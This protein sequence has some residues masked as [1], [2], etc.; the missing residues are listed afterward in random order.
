MD[1]LPRLRRLLFLALAASVLDLAGE[2]AMAQKVP[3][4]GEKRVETAEL[5][6]GRRIAGR[7]V[8]ATAGSFRF[9]TDQGEAI[10]LDKIGEITVDGPGPEPSTGPP[11]FQIQLGSWSRLSGR[12]LSIDGSTIRVDPGSDHPPLQVDRHGVTSVIQRPGEVQSLKDGFETLD[13]NRWSPGGDADLVAIP[14]LVGDR[15]ARLPAGGSSL[16]MRLVEPLGSGRLELAYFDEGERVPGQRW[17]VDLTF[18]R[19][20]SESTTVRVVL[21]WAEETLAVETPGGPALNVQRLVRKPGWH[22]LAVKFEPERAALSV[23]GDELAHG[24]GFGGPLFEIRMATE[25]LGVVQPLKTLGAVVDDLSLVRFTQPTGRF[26]VE[27]AQDE[28]RLLSGDQ[29]FGRFLGADGDRLS[30]QLDGKTIRPSW[31]D[32]SGIHFRR[33]AASADPISGLWVRVE[34]RT[35]PGNDIRDLDRI[36]A[37]L[38]AIDEA[39]LTLDAPYV[40][41]FAVPRDRVRK[42]STLAP[43]TRIVVDPN[44]HHLG[45]RVTPDLDP[46]QPEIAPV[47]VTFELRQVPLQPSSLVMDVVKVIGLEGTPEFSEMVK[48]GQLRTRLSLNGVRLDDLNVHVPSQNE[49]PQRVRVP[50]P[51]MG[52]SVG[53]NVL[54]IEQT[55]SKDARK[56]RD[57]LGIL[58]IAI[59]SAPIKATGAAKP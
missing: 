51:A 30:F 4:A 43:A 3:A 25:T 1:N 11:P 5:P 9:Q 54:R 16:T 29:L 22:R 34:W 23:D 19:G 45:D 40:G 36:E 20:N 50:I 44:S 39:N 55:E 56:Q 53:K 59:E 26:E 52:L 13:F 42:I 47:E 31:A 35:A 46:P 21:G 7:I 41:R 58:S 14:H 6:D 57:N 37:A 48:M 8:E 33:A 12:L 17:F 10:P 2:P 15:A 38:V 28:V 32:V 49:T 27:P 18:R 24:H